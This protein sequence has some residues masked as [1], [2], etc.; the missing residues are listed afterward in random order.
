MLS[1][2]LRIGLGGQAVAVVDQPLDVADPDGDLG[3]LVGV[4]VDLD[5]VQLGGRDGDEEAPGAQLVRQADHLVLQVEQQAQGHVQ[6]VAAAAGRV[7]HLDGGDLVGKA[8]SWAPIFCTPAA[9]FLLAFAVGF[10]LQLA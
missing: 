1:M 6:E 8:R 10:G 9:R 7:E 5:A 3:Q 4:L 2:R